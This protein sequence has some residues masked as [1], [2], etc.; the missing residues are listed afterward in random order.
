MLG[1]VSF[2]SP[3][4]VSLYVNSK[5]HCLENTLFVCSLCNIY[6]LSKLFSFVYATKSSIVQ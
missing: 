1:A 2:G 5:L 3:F 6:A 4:T